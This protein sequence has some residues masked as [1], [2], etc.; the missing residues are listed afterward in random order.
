MVVEEEQSPSGRPVGGRGGT[1]SLAA[2]WEE[3]RP[4]EG[5]RRREP[6]GMAPPGEVG[7]GGRCEP[8]RGGCRCFGPA[9]Y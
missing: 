4:T 2:A 1:D 8:T 5:R 7:G 6:V 3:R 9:T